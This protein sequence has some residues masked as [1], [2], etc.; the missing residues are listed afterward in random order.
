MSTAFEDAWMKKAFDIP[1]AVVDVL[2]GIM[3]PEVVEACDFGE[4]E[5]LST[6]YVADDLSQSVGDAVWRIR[7]AG[8]EEW[9]YLLLVLEFQ[10][11]VDSDMASRMHAYVGQL[12]R[13]LRRNKELPKGDRL[14]PVLPMVIYTGSPPWTAATELLVAPPGSVLEA[15]QPRQRFFLID[16]HRLN[17]EDLPRRNLLSLRARFAQRDWTT[18]GEDLQA[19][20]VDPETDASLA[21]LFKEL[22]QHEVMQSEDVAPGVKAQFRKLA[23]E[24]DLKEMGSFLDTAL[25]ESRQQGLEQGLERGLEQ[26]L[27]QGLERQRAMLLRQAARKFDAGTAA[28]LEA[29][30]TGI[31][32]PHR[33]DEIGDHLI[34]SASGDELLSW[35]P[36]E[37]H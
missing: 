7:F 17:A 34:D 36:A 15:Y 32:D 24:G 21:D 28:K 30:L 18:V 23:E 6:Q 14:P 19:L 35:E 31:D 37:R 11:T 16:I 12:Y 26:G 8:S 25:F 29:L 13:K 9:L 1:G 5:Q 33:L 27:E 3:P 22:L 20:A 4:M 2:R 10:S